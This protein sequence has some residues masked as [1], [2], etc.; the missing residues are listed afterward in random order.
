MLYIAKAFNRKERR[1]FAKVA[2][3]GCAKGLQ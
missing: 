3:A 1:D 2:K